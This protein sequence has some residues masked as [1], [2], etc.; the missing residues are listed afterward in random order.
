MTK[1]KIIDNF[2]S[3]S[4]FTELTGKILPE[5]VP[6]GNIG[7]IPSFSWHYTRY[8]MLVGAEAEE[9]KSAEDSFKK[10]T[11]IEISNPINDWYFSH[12]L[13]YKSYQS[14]ELRYCGPLLDKINPVA[15]FKV[16]ANFTVQQEKRK[17]PLFHVDYVGKTPMITSIFYMNTTNGPT[18]LEDGTEIECRANRLVS[19]PHETHHSGAVCTD[20]P[21]RIVINF[22]YFKEIENLE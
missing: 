7:N 4:E 11:N 13:Y 16:R 18:I 2:L 20:Q 19:F 14:P 9:A 5:E 12:V 3:D 21:Y 10:V 15:L 1:Y 6:A 22:N 8:R 17:R